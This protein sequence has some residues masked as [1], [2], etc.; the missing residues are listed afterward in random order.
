MAAENIA[1]IE[2]IVPSASKRNISA[3]G[4]TEIVKGLKKPMTV[5]GPDVIRA[6]GQAIPF[7]GL[8][9]G[10]AYVGHAVRVFNGRSPGL[11]FG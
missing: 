7:L 4:H 10:M 9:I 6:A 3:I 11:T 5:G 8:L 2:S 1:Q